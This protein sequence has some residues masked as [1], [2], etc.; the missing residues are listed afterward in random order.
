MFALINREKVIELSKHKFPVAEPLSW[1][2][3][4]KE[5]KIG[6]LYQNKK[7]K[8]VGDDDFLMELKK[9]LMRELDHYYHSSEIRMT[10]YNS[11]SFENRSNLRSLLS[12][13][14]IS[15]NELARQGLEEDML[16]FNLVDSQGVEH[17]LNVEK[18]AQI[19][20]FLE[21]KRQKQFLQK[22]LHRL[23]ILSLKNTTEVQQYNF[24]SGW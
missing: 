8:S 17:R 3:S 20:N 11:I 19:L 2:K 16:F 9:S 1:V 18:L 23:T 21:N 13:Q 10:K 22:E 7:F 14:I 5:T 15:L 4:D 24:K 6:D 12:R